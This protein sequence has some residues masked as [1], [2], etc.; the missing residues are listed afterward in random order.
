[1]C[2]VSLYF[3]L[4]DLILSSSVSLVISFFLEL[5]AFD[6]FTPF[7]TKNRLKNDSILLLFNNRIKRLLKNKRINVVCKRL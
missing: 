2:C 1:M 7:E 6:E 5:L 4:T 3:L